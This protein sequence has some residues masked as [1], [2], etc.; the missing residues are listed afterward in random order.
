MARFRFR[1]E[2]ALGLA[3]RRLEDKQRI[4]AQEIQKL[5]NLQKARGEK[6]QAWL[7]A[8]EG[9]KE[10]CK[11]SIQDLPLWQVFTQ[12]Q[13]DILRQLEKQVLEQEKVVDAKRKELLEA[14]QEAE[15]LRRLKA[16]QK[17]IFDL[18]EQRREQAVLEEAGQ[19]IVGRR[20]KV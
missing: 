10:A 6:E 11:T 16:K 7:L 4:L 5:A 19:I 3:E 18:M 20:S 9:Q 15:K 8:L 13:L 14:H 17:A 12:K 1:L 2:A